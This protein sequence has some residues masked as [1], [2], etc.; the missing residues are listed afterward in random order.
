LQAFCDNIIIMPCTIC[1]HVPAEN[2]QVPS[3]PVLDPFHM[4]GVL[5][6]PEAKQVRLCLSQLCTDIAH[7]DNAAMRSRETTNEL[8]FAQQVLGQCIKDNEAIFAPIHPEIFS[9]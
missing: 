7:L 2:I 4:P 9:Q 3:F 1:E 8:L 5:S 6:Q